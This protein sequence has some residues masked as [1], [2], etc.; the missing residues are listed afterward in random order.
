MRPVNDGGVTGSVVVDTSQSAGARLRPV[1]ISAV[2]LEGGLW[3][4]RCEANR[5]AGLPRL[6]DRLE[7]HGVVDNFRR[8]VGNGSERRGLWFTDSDLYK[9]MEGAAW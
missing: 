4:A 2:T 8:K 3:Q 9:W 1:A 7:A 5:V 6:H